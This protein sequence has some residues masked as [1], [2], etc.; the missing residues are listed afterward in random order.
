[1]LRERAGNTSR[2]SM[3]AKMKKDCVTSS[4]LRWKQNI[5]TTASGESF[6]RGGKTDLLL[7]Y[8][9]DSSNLFVA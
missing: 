1:M 2:Q 9:N 3:W 6:N 7:N 5:R 8:A 4:F